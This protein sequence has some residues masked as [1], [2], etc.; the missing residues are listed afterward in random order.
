MYAKNS[1]TLYAPSNVF[2]ENGSGAI[3]LYAQGFRVKTGSGTVFNLGA[4]SNPWNNVYANGGEILPSD[5]NLKHDVKEI[6]QKYEDLFFEIEPCT[7]IYNN[8]N[9]THIG[10]ISQKIEE[11]LK[12]VGLTAEEFAGFCKDKKTIDIVDKN[13]NV[14]E[15]FVFDEEGNPLFI[16]SLRYSEFIML[17]THMI[18]K[19]YNVIE[20]QQSEIDELK[21]SVSFL[22]EKLGCMDN[23]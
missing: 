15:E 23:E 10:A 11:A 13:G 5:K 3:G 8:G 17:N 12:K 14:S 4:S 19:A 22:M 1:M 18:Q 20:R 7:Y 6:S 16:Y 2:F 9:R 21:Q